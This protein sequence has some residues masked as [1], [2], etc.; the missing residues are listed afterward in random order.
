ML[1]ENICKD[2]SEVNKCHLLDSIKFKLDNSNDV[3]ERNF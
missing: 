3:V 1:K 2:E